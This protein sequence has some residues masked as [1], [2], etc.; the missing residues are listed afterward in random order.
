MEYALVDHGASGGVCGTDMLVLKGRESFVDVIR[1][2]G[3]KVSRLR[4]A[5]AQAMVTTHKG[6][7][8]ATFHQMVHQMALLGKGKK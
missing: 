6:D 1:L 8:I 4:I 7:G 3:H 2:T 5:I